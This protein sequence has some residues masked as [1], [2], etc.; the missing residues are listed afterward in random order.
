MSEEHI[1]LLRIISELK[2]SDSRT[3]Q[4]LGAEISRH[5]VVLQ[6][7]LT[8]LQLYAEHLEACGACADYVGNCQEGL[9]LRRKA[10]PD[11]GLLSEE[12]GVPK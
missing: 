2:T 7:R 10:M 5:V 3:N 9:Q 4:A 6:S 8:A 1:E 12:V 11:A